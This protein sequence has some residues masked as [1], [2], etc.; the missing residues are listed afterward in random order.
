MHNSPLVTALMAQ[1]RHAMTF[2]QAFGACIVDA[3]AQPG[4]RWRTLSRGR[5]KH[6][7]RTA[8]HCCLHS[9][10][11]VLLWH[12]CPLLPACWLVDA[13]YLSSLTAWTSVDMHPIAGGA[14][15]RDD[16]SGR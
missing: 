3:E 2:E 1:V 13:P 7:S 16:G 11:H 8:G 6:Q 12:A 9:L 14:D 10:T 5:R 15:D 4:A